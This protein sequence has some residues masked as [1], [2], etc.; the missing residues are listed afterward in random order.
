VVQL[1]SSICQMVQFWSKS[2][3]LHEP[4]ELYNLFR[5]NNSFSSNSRR[6]AESPPLRQL[7]SS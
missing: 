5:I 2:G 1:W 7:L 3:T 6:D 4:D